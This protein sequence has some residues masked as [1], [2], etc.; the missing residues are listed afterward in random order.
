MKKRLAALILALAMGL[1]LGSGVALAE[2]ETAEAEQTAAQDEEGTLSFEN[3]ESRIRENNYTLLALERQIESIDKTDLEKT[4]KDLLDGLNAIADAQWGMISSM[5]LVGSMASS[6]MQSSYDA[7]RQQLDDIKDGKTARNMEN[8]RRQLSTAE[9]QLVLGM[10]LAYIQIKGAQTQD[11]ALTRGIAA[12]DRGVQTAQVSYQHGLVSKLAVEQLSAQRTQLAS[13]QKTLHMGVDTGVMNLKA[14][15]GMELD[16]PLTLGEL[17]KV[18]AAQI[19]AM[20]VE[21]DLAR[22]KENSS[23]LFDAKATLEDANKAVVDKYYSEEATR[24]WQAAQYTYKAT[25]QSFELKFRTLYAQ[26]LDYAQ[27]LEAARAALTVE[28]REYKASALKYSQEAISKNA[29]ADAQDALA[30]AKDAVA[31]AE[32]D[33]LTAY[34]SYCWAVEYGIL[35]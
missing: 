35:N 23:T 1:T 29:L 12:L 32:S 26:V 5:G 17:P 4:R 30:D 24:T 7:M 10:E 25:E 21:A 31:S 33:L 20:D 16:A 14:A 3:L 13:T 18:T 34:R 11:A 15:V 22:A 28:Q 6:M 19:D 2:N 8:A 27:K 9:A